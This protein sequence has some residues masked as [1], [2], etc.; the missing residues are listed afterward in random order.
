[1]RRASPA[2]AE[3]TTTNTARMFITLKPL[4][5]RKATAAGHRAAAQKARSGPGAPTYLQPCRTCASAEGWAMPSTS[6]RSR[7]TTWPSSTAWAPRVAPADAHPAPTGRRE[8][9]SAE[10][11]A[12]ESVVIDR[13]TA[14][15]LGITP[16]LI[17]DTLYDAFG[18]R[19]VSITIPF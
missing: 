7:G 16:Q 14:S 12:A 13:D 15:R 5:E 8:Q 1:M 2:A 17:D 19:Q 3:A 9:R 18:Q 11:R 6:T 4:A 10:Q